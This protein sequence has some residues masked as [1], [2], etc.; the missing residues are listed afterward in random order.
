MPKTRYFFKQ[1]FYRDV[2]ECLVKQERIF[3][4]KQITGQLYLALQSAPKIGVSFQFPVFKA[5]GINI[6]T[7]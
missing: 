7:S 2:T 1:I 3:L 4:A 6:E 5:E